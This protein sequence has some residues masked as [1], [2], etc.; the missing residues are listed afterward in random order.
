MHQV[1][2]Q[3]KPCSLNNET[4]FPFSAY[5]HSKT[6]IMMHPNTL[7]GNHLIS[8]SIFFSFLLLCCL[9]KRI[10]L[11]RHTHQLSAKFHLVKAILQIHSLSI[12]HMVN[13]IPS[14][15]GLDDCSGQMNFS[16]PVVHF[17]LRESQTF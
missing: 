3:D 15:T 12:T 11:H 2:S 13:F 7:Q 16:C 8:V 6:S 9:T 14:A 4:I 10:C 1:G 5:S 17:L